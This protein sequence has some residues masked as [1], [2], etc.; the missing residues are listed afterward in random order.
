[1]FACSYADGHVAITF[2]EDHRRPKAPEPRYASWGLPIVQHDDHWLPLLVRAWE[3]D[4]ATVFTSG[5]RADHELGYYSPQRYGTADNAVITIGSLEKDGEIWENDTPEGPHPNGIDPQCIGHRDA[6]A[7]SVDVKVV[8]GTTRNDIQIASGSSFAAPQ[9]AGLI[10]YWMGLPEQH[11]PRWDEGQVA[12]GAKR[13]LVDRKRKASA[14]SPDALGAICSGVREL[15]CELE[16][17]NQGTSKERRAEGMFQNA[18]EAAL[19]EK[20]LAMVN[21]DPVGLWS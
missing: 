1:M 17:Q 4:I 21:N 15:L 12:S 18:T 2:E 20:L 14:N 10:A 8:D 19:T 11:R 9:A 3:L 6:Y 7:L 5:N 16:Q 13:T